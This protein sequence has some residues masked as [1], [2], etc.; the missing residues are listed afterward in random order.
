MDEKYPYYNGQI[1]ITKKPEKFL[2]FFHKDT[3]HTTLDNE[4][5]LRLLFLQKIKISSG[6]PTYLF[7]YLD[8]DLEIE[9]FNLHPKLKKILNNPHSLN[10]KVLSTNEI[11]V[12]QAKLYK[13]F[14]SKYRSN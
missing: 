14:I 3:I 12:S 9:D 1:I 7:L 2:N 10:I 5:V 6:N 4:Y 13:S 11:D 8:E